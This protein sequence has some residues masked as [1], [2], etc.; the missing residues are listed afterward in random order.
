MVLPPLLPET[1]AIESQITHVD[2]PALPAGSTVTA[3]A[4]RPDGSGASCAFNGMRELPDGTNVASQMLIEHHREM[5]TSCFQIEPQLLEP[6]GVVLCLRYSQNTSY[7][8]VAVTNGQRGLVQIWETPSDS[9]SPKTQREPCAWKIFENTLLDVS[10][11]GDDTFLAC[12]AGG[13]SAMY[14]IDQN[15]QQEI[16]AVE[17]GTVSMRGL[18]SQNSDVLEGSHDWDKVRWDDQHNLA[19]FVS[20]MEKRM[21]ISSRLQNGSEGTGEEDLQ[22]DLPEEPTALAFKPKH[23]QAE[24]EDP[25][26]LAAAFVDGSCLV[27]RIDRSG[28]AGPKCSEL[29]SLSLDDG[30]ALAVAWSPNGQYLA[31]GNSELVQI[32]SADALKRQNGVRHPPQAAVIWRPAPEVNG[33]MNGHAQDEKMPEP[34][35]SWSADGESLAY[36]ADKQVRVTTSVRHEKRS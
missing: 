16:G 23:G 12:G 20:S 10:W 33:T 13:L 18:I 31:V 19:V 15:R 8:L 24:A 35:L 11:T 2:E 1:D 21:V 30:P 26:L 22:I 36:A 3:S 6:P 34:S 4:W 28:D 32:W 7:L 14:Q 5:G 9:N 17:A 27:Y 25:S 29:V